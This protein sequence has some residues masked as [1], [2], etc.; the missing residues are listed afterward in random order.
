MKT[1]K[2]QKKLLKEKQKNLESKL[3]EIDNSNVTESEKEKMKQEA[4][5]DFENQ[6]KKLESREEKLNQVFH[7][8]LG[9]TKISF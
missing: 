1:K 9:K 8:H 4:E 6:K 7:V 3:I 5:I 2:N